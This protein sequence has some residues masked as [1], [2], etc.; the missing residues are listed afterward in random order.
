MVI[1]VIC[2]NQ[3]T[4]FPLSQFSEQCNL[5]NK[6][7]SCM[8]EFKRHHKMFKNLQNITFILEY[9]II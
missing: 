2:M 9:R 6:D 7:Y 4:K 5:N 3:V 8:K 1:Q